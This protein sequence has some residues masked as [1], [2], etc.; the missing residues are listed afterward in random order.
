MLDCMSSP[1]VLEFKIFPE[2]G[3]IYFLYAKFEKKGER[4]IINVQ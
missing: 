1:L 3:K 2:T 4:S